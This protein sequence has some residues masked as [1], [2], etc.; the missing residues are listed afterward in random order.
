[1]KRC[2]EAGEKNHEIVMKTG[3]SASY[4]RYVKRYM[5]DPQK[6]KEQS[7]SQKI[8]RDWKKQFAEEWEK[9]VRKIW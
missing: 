9:T 6:V 3:C 8:T 2:I 4:I 1:M 5:S 7:K